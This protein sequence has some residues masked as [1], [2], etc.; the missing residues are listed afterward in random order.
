MAPVDV[1]AGFGPGDQRMAIDVESGGP[2]GPYRVARL[3][4][5]SPRRAKPSSRRRGRR[6]HLIF[7]TTVRAGRTAYAAA[8]PASASL[9]AHGN[10]PSVHDGIASGHTLCRPARRHPVLPRAGPD[11]LCDPLTAPHVV[12]AVAPASYAAARAAT[13]RTLRSFLDDSWRRLCC[14]QPNG[15]RS[16]TCD[17]TRRHEPHGVGTNR[18]GAESAPRLNGSILGRHRSSIERA[19]NG[20]L[21]RYHPHNNTRVRSDHYRRSGA[22]V[23]ASWW[24]THECRAAHM[25][26]RAV[27]RQ[28]RL[29]VQSHSRDLGNVAAI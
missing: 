13:W 12:E 17:L 14:R 24:R 16:T 25:P 28:G 29:R 5:R 2:G 4:R 20:A 3:V 1:V 23:R 8:A 6:Y 7:T 21:N 15:R 22:C 19:D 10:C 26:E 9:P 11:V 27:L 18:S